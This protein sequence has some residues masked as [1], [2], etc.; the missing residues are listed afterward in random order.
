MIAMY[1]IAKLLEFFDAGIYGIFGL[2]SGHSLKHVAASLG[3]LALLFALRSR[4]R[5]AREDYAN[6]Q[7]GL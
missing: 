2:I 6:E 7:T 1:V 4:G 3:P 5:A